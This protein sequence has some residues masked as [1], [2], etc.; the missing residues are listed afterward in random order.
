MTRI[1]NRIRILIQLPS[2]DPDPLQTANRV[3][4]FVTLV[5]AGSRP[6]FAALGDGT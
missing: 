3:F 4:I 2:P 6:F 1:R 5:R